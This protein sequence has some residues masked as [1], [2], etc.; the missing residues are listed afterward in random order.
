MINHIVWLES[1]LQLLSGRGYTS[2][3]CAYKHAK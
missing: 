3:P 2:L 1:L